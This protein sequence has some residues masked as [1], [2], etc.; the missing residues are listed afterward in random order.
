VSSLFEATNFLRTRNVRH[1][2]GQKSFGMGY[3][4]LSERNRSFWESLPLFSHLLQKKGLSSSAGG[5]NKTGTKPLFGDVFDQNAVGSCT[6]ESSCK[7]SRI[8]L[9]GKGI[10]PAGISDFSQRIMYGQTRQIEAAASVAAGQPIPDISDS[11]CE[12]A[13]CVKAMTDFGLAPMEAPVGGYYND[14]WSGNVNREIVLADEEKTL[15]L[16]GAHLID[17]SPSNTSLIQEWQAG[18]NANL[19]MTLALFVDTTNFMGYNGSAPIQKINLSD[20]QGGGHQITGPLAWYTSSSL[21]LVWTFGNS[22]SAS[23]G[24]Q[25]FGEITHDCLMTAID[26]SIAMDV[27]LASGGVS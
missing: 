1:V 4:T 3:R 6:A 9:L 7:A 16:P 13:D 25:G 5:D 27:S 8:T 18:V 11:G 21:G 23:W 24:V 12:P 26:A 2:T 22:W 19:G 14:V 15:I 20:P 10:L 17:V